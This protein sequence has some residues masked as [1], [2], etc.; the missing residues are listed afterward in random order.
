MS[1]KEIEYV[2]VPPLSYTIST[3]NIYKLYDVLCYELSFEKM[4]IL[5]G[6]LK[7]KMEYLEDEPVYYCS[8][9]KDE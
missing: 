4:I 7:H 3:M 1:N 6:L 8:E 2:T 9:A 5:Y